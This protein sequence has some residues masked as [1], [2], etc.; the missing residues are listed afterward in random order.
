M[1]DDR[2]RRF[3]DG[4]PGKTDDLTQFVT[5]FW[6]ERIH[7]GKH[8]LSVCPDC[9]DSYSTLRSLKTSAS[10]PLNLGS[11]HERAPSNAATCS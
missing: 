9:V 3:S 5:R 4:E 7:A 1:H 10:Y 11:P 2:I 8:P 6:C